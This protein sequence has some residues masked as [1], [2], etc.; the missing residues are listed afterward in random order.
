[1]I[2]LIKAQCLACTLLFSLQL[3]P[4]AK[5]MSSLFTTKQHTN[6]HTLETKLFDVRM[7]S[8]IRQ[9]D[10][11]CFTRTP[12][13]NVISHSDTRWPMAKRTSLH[14][15]KCSTDFFKMSRYRSQSERQKHEYLYFA[16]NM[17]ISLFKVLEKNSQKEKSLN[18]WNS[19]YVFALYFTSKPT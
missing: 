2:Q 14:G 12:R 3:R 5:V 10:V 7:S 18:I 4:E 11:N 1:M 6:R 13:L 9:T 17:C 16:L 8:A 19:N 15:N